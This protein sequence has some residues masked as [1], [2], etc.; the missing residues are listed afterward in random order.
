[1]VFCLRLADPK[2]IHGGNDDGKPSKRNWGTLY[3][4]TANFGENSPSHNNTGAGPRSGG[5][6]QLDVWFLEDSQWCSIV[7]WDDWDGEDPPQNHANG[8]T[9]ELT[10][11]HIW[12][13]PKI[14]VPPNR[15]FLLG[16]IPLK[17]MIWGTPIL[18]NTH[19]LTQGLITF[20]Y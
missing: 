19:L 6:T 5:G 13:F 1:M 17:W 9:I 4:Q 2:G 3:F 12:G 10:M 14:W 15:W 20:D 11:F 16:K 7:S 8:R 18:G